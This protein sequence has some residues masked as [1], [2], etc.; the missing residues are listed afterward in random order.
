MFKLK[1]TII[2]VLLCILLSSCSDNNQ[3]NELTSEEIVMNELCDF[4][5]D[6]VIK[7]F[8]PTSQKDVDIAVSNALL[9]SDEVTLYHFLIK[10]DKTINKD[11]SVEN[12]NVSY[13]TAEGSI[14]VKPS[15]IVAFDKYFD[16]YLKQ[17]YYARFELDEN[18]K[19]T[20]INVYFSNI[21]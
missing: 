19:I 18:M 5:S 16:D 6:F 11:Y 2:I 10:M 17:T 3:N 4:A 15:L 14:N 13:S 8:A 12:L 20:D 7:M 1:R 9:W 21:T